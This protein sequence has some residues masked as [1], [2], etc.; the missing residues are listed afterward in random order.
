[1]KKNSGKLIISSS[2]KS[3]DILYISKLHIPDEFIYVEIAGINKKIIAVSSLE[4]SR[5]KNS[6]SAD[7]EVI[8]YEELCNGETA[9]VENSV[10]ALIKK[11]SL[12]ELAVPFDFPTG[13]YQLL[14]TNNVD[15]NVV[16]GSFFPERL[17]KNNFEL[18]QIALAQKLNEQTI[19][20]G[21]SLLRESNVNDEKMLILD[22]EIL[23]SERFKGILNSFMVKRGGYCD[24]L[25]ASC[26]AAAA[27][28]H[29]TGNGP[30]Y[31]NQTIVIDNF[32][33]L[34]SSHYWGDMTRTVVKGK[35]SAMVNKAFNA[36][37]EAKNCVL[38][39][40]RAGVAVKDLHELAKNI[41]V[42]NGFETYVHDN[43]CHVGFIHG[44]GHGLGLD[45]HEA[46][47]VSSANDYILE[48][49]TV[50]TIEPGLYYPEW[51]GMRLEDLVVVKG[52]GCELLNNKECI[53]EI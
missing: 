34:S 44:L 29:N 9:D 46:P 35:A 2:E 52:N 49:N 27:E 8:S 4:Y 6:G 3:S 15:I 21:I 1:M 7:C 12:Q 31:A 14:K 50:I 38:E 36:V 13:Y 19:N 11:Y 10:I 41:L 51:G 24:T 20:Y 42:K 33:R 23:T 16:K 43:G 40:V 18:K 5:A 25:I 22:G 37:Y 17:I 48:E 26:G 53:L 39:K 30:L 47:R 28:P 32:P 45:I